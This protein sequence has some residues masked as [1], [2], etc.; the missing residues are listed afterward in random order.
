MVNTTANVL[1]SIR[2]IPVFESLILDYVQLLIIG[3]EQEY[4]ADCSACRAL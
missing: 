3:Q 4:T 1:L 2:N